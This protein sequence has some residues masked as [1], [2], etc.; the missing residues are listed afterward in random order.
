MSSVYQN[1]FGTVY[2]GAIY[3]FFVSHCYTWKAKQRNKK[4]KNNQ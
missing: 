1:S 4:I 3:V 2:I